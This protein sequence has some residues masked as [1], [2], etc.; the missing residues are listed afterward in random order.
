MYLP[1]PPV[2]SG[3]SQG[4]PTHLGRPNPVLLPPDHSPNQHLNLAGPFLVKIKVSETLKRCSE[5][6]GKFHQ[7]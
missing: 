2:I 7:R 5:A 4:L 1:S 6:R 3:N